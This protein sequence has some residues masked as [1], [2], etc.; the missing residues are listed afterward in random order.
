MIEGFFYPFGSACA[1]SLHAEPTIAPLGLS[2]LWSGAK[3][4]M[5]LLAVLGTAWDGG[6]CYW[7]NS[8]QRGS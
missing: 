4:C 8:K 3:H 2:V 1:D 6:T 5:S 7:R